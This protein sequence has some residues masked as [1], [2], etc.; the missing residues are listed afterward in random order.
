MN[1]QSIRLEEVKPYKKNAKVHSDTQVANIAESI[2][3]FGW[4]QPIVID[5]K[6]EIVIG[7]GRYMAAQLLGLEEIPVVKITD[8]TQKQIKALRIADNKLNESSWD[9]DILR[10]ELD[11]ID[12]ENFDFDFALPDLDDFEDP[13]EEDGYYGDERERTYNS[14]NLADY[15][16]ARATNKWNMP[17]IQATQHIP[18]DLISFN[19]VLSSKDYNKGVHFYIDDY[20]FERVWNRPHEYIERLS[21]FDC[22]LT[23]DFSMYTDMPLAMQIW[24]VYRSRLIG[25]VMQD[26]GL[27]VIPTLQWCRE[28][29]FDFCFEGLQRGG[30]VSVSTIGVKRDKEATQIWMTGMDE[31]I[32]RLKPSFVIVYGGDIG[33]D[34]PCDVKYI[35]NHNSDRLKNGREALG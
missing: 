4:T 16:P 19:Y 12:L 18:E 29:S 8:L 20:Q 33:Y 31:A 3:Q 35:D 6:N 11:D 15:D 30:V 25:Q 23:P 2:R 10:E 28:N 13:E 21:K 1:I 17:I 22:V 34:F 27:T 32:K 26:A 9:I 24:N 7:H 14:V 5:K